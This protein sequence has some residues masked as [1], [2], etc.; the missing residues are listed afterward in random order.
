M[1]NTG[2]YAY[3]D[4]TLVKQYCEIANTVWCH[5]DSEKCKRQGGSIYA[6]SSG[7]LT[8]LEGIKQGICIQDMK[9]DFNDEEGYVEQPPSDGSWW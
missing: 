6:H 1:Q 7:A 4:P 2:E 9:I 8:L 5:G 3:D